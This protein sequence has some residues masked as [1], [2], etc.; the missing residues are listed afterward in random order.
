[1][2]YCAHLHRQPAETWTAAQ[3]AAFA[4]KKPRRKAA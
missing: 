4:V 2:A 1:V 3:V